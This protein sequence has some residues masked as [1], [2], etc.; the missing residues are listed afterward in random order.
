MTLEGGYKFNELGQAFLASVSPLIP[1]YEFSKEPE[2]NLSSGGN[3]GQLKNTLDELKSI[4]K[5]YWR[6]D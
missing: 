1:D 5:P 4:L 2:S 6:I 3:K